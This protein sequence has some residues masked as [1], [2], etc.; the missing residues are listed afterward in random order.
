MRVNGTRR[1]RQVKEA[2]TG[3]AR[4]RKNVERDGGSYH[5]RRSRS[6]VMCAS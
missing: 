4:S 2:R 5:P 1:Y 3:G 6:D